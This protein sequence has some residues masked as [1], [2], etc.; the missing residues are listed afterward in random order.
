MLSSEPNEDDEERVGSGRFLNK[1]ELEQMTPAEL[2]TGEQ[3][4]MKI[5]KVEPS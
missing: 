3:N 5:Q 4:L 2:W 1:A